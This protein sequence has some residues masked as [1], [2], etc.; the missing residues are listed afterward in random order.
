MAKKQDK[1]LNFTDFEDYDQAPEITVN[2]P[3]NISQDGKNFC[4]S[5]SCNFCDVSL[6]RN[7]HFL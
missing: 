4:L 6:S 5:I 1:L 7:F 2:Q 3:K